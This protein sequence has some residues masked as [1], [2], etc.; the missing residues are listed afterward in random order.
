MKCSGKMVLC[1]AGTL[2]LTPVVRA[3][4]NDSAPAINPA[5]EADSN[6][7]QPYSAIWVRNVFDLKAKEAPAPPPTTNPP[8]A[9]V[10][11]L[12]ITTLFSKRALISVQPANSPGQP[13]QK[14]QTYTMTE[15]ERHGL[16]DTEVVHPKLM[17]GPDLRVLARLLRD[18]DQ[19]GIG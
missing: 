8:P 4:I 2:A 6:S 7:E 17:D 1:L 16:I 12:G 18:D 19:P 13:P 3:V 15:G 5:P 9:N 11:L 14:E 10:H